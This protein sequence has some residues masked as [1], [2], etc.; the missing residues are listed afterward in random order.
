M[1]GST[2]GVREGY[3]GVRTYAPET[4]A[5]R[6]NLLA[7]QRARIASGILTKALAKAKKSPQPKVTGE[8]RAVSGARTRDLRL[9]KP[10]LY[11]L[12]YYRKK[13][14]RQRFP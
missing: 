12:S 5:S 2:E 11:Q 8:K 4:P 3:G 1:R 6:S 13:G 9:G 7:C 14:T 10:L